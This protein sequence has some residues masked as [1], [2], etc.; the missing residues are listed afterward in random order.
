MHIHNINHDI[1]EKS[2]ANLLLKKLKKAEKD[3]VYAF[4]CK[5]DDEFLM[6]LA[7][8]MKLQ[9]KTIKSTII[10]CMQVLEHLRESD[11]IRTVES[12][13]SNLSIFRRH[14]NYLNRKAYQ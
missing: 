9:K 10:I 12:R 4:Y 14:Q 8:V 3:L 11:T 13:L 5:E 1:R 2:R 6:I 7:N